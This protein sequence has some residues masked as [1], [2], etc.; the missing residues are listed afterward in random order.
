M[1]ILSPLWSK[2]S[3][4]SLPLSE[5]S[6]KESNPSKSHQ[7]EFLF[8]SKPSSDVIVK[9]NKNGNLK[10]ILYQFSDLMR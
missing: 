8:S 2:I 9:E 6:L 5:S 1:D 7:N 3:S 10:S 4:G